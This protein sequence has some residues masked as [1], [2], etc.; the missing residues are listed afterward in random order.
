[1]VATCPQVGARAIRQVWGWRNLRFHFKLQLTSQMEEERESYEIVR[2]IV[3]LAHNLGLKVVAE[4]VETAAQVERL[5]LLNCDFVQGYY[6]SKPADHQAI[7]DLLLKVNQ[8][9][10]VARPALTHK[11]SAGC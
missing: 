7:S 4:G 10:P 11:A 3:T 1:M 2:T 6:F 8:S 9:S 5:S